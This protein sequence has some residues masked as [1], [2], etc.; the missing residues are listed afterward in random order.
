MLRARPSLT[1]VTPV[2]PGTMSGQQQPTGRQPV[3]RTETITSR[4]PDQLPLRLA[5]RRGVP[6]GVVRHVDRETGRTHDTPVPMSTSSGAFV[7]PL[8]EGTE[9]DWYRDVRAA[10]SCTVAWQGS[11]YIGGSPRLVSPSVGRAAFPGPLHRLLARNGVE[12]YLWVERGPEL[13]GAYRDVAVR[14]P[15]RPIVAGLAWV[16]LVAALAVWRP[17]KREE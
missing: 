2:I 17:W 13:P 4:L 6:Y 11:A 9:P 16:A 12:E 10:G 14:Y 3:S 15:S 7:V 5:G 8:L 1:S